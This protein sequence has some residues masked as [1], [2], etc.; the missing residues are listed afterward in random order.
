MLKKKSILRLTSLL[1]VFTCLITSID[2]QYVKEKR[3]TR[4]LFIFDA[5]NSMNGYW[6]SG[7]KFDIARKILSKLVDSLENIENTQLALRI[8]GHQVGPPY[9]CI[10][11]KLEVPFDWKNAPKIR[12]KLNSVSPKGTTPIAYSLEQSA[13]DFTKCSNCKNVIVLITDGL[14]ECEGDPCAIAIKLAEKGISLKPYVIG[15]GLK[16]DLKQAFE[17]VGKFYD[18]DHEVEFEEVLKDVVENAFSQTSAQINLLDITR[19]PTETNVNLTFYNQQTN[20]FLFNSIHTLNKLGNPD[21]IFLEPRITYKI[22]VN[23]IPPVVKNDIKIVSK[24]HNIIEIPAAQGYLRIEQEKG[25]DYNNDKF[26][27]KEAGKAETIYAQEFGTTEKYLVGFYD[28]EILC[29]PRIL[30]KNI[31]IKQ[32]QTNTLKIPEPGIANFSMP[33]TG[34]GSLY[35][36]RNGTQEWVCNLNQFTRKVLKL[37]PGNYLAIYRTGLGTSMNQS[38]VRKF[39]VVSGRSLSVDF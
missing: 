15:I 8:Y 28:I 23:T 14:E 32:S 22:V 4:I 34:Y 10:D 33:S 37:Q 26:V 1:L 9:S 39:T 12:E 21:T 20:E 6:E 19:K 36:L 31:E 24:K 30:L 18:A 17:C 27:V 7:K 11:S 29:L 35:V 38:N 2:A 13:G 5:S 16:V 25:N 3:T